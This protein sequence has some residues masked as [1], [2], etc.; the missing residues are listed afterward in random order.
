MDFLNEY[1]SWCK[2]FANS[3]IEINAATTDYSNLVNAVGGVNARCFIDNDDNLWITTPY[4]Q[5]YMKSHIDAAIDEYNKSH[6]CCYRII[7]EKDRHMIAQ[8][9]GALCFSVWCKVP[10]SD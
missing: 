6:E 3:C 8:H 10:I 7:E 9:F 4:P 5:S 2:A 1:T